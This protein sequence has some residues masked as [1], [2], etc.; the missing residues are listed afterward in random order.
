MR[1]IDLT[2]SPNDQLPPPQTFASY[3]DTKSGKTVFAATWPRT[4]FFSD[5]SEGGYESLRAENWNDELTPLF[6][7]DVRPI[8]WGISEMADM[9]NCMEKA[10][11]L[12]SSGRVRTIVTDSITFYSD[13]YLNHI[14]GQQKEPDNR[15]AYGKL[16]VH[17]RWLRIEMHKLGVNAGWLALAQ[18]PEKDDKG[19]LIYKGKPSIPGKEADK[20]MAGVNFTFFH[21]TVRPQP[22]KP[23]VFEMHTREYSNYLAGNRLGKRAQMLP[24]PMTSPTYGKVLESLGY[25]VDAVRKS[26]P[27]ISKTIEIKSIAPATRPTVSVPAAISKPSPIKITTVAK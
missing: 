27:D 25:D 14:L 11:P 19:N 26:L 9:A 7:P 20:F 4:L 22:T 17:L 5:I 3:G 23:P 13:L 12:I 10:K 24:E 1:E 6:E 21:S 16:G 8:V 18:H 15:Q 2:E